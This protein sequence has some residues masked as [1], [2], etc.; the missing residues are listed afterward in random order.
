[1]RNHRGGRKA[2]RDGVRQDRGETIRDRPR[3]SRDRFRGHDAEKDLDA[4]AP[5]VRRQGRQPVRALLSGGPAAGGLHGQGLCGYS[6]V[7]G[8]EVEGGGAG[9][10]LR[11]GQPGAG[12]RLRA[13]AENKAV[14]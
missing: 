1:M 13:G 9:G 4:G 2:T 10:A 8:G 14:G 3:R 5:D 7:P 11:G 6:G 12:V